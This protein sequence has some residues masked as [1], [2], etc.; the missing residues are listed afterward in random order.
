[1]LHWLQL[2]SD[3][4]LVT[5]FRSNFGFVCIALCMEHGWMGKAS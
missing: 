5:V 4:D 2:C 3:K 1:M